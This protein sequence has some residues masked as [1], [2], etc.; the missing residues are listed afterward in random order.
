MM[1]PDLILISDVWGHD[2]HIDQL[3]AEFDGLVSALA[4]AD[5]ALTAVNQKVD[6]LRPRIDVL[7]AQEKVKTREL[8]SYQEQRDRTRRLIDSGASPNYA[9]SE[10]Q[11]Q[12]VSGIIDRLENESLELMDAR[13]GLERSHKILL[14]EQAA[15]QETKAAAQAAK[16]EREPIL[17]ADMAATLPK[18]EAAWKLMPLDWRSHYEEL[19]RKKRPALVN[20]EEGICQR[21]Q[22]RVAPQWVIEVRMMRAV[23]TCPGCQGFLLP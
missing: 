8:E 1:H 15:A 21:C 3:R 23:H 4:R 13:E 18:R 9:A 10:K 20:V 5:Q 7:R 11:L 22:M 6:E 19:R 14:R 16:S 2:A 17:R 12:Q